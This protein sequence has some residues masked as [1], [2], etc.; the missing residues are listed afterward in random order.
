[1]SFDILKEL[2][3]G[4]GMMLMRNAEALNY[5]TS[6]PQTERLAVAKECTIIRT[7][8]DMRRYVEK[9]GRQRP[10]DAP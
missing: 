5:Y 2:P 7:E 1:M 8:E 4:F 3:M 10:F 9:L 6:L